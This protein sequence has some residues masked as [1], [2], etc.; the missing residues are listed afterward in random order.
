MDRQLTLHIFQMHL[1]NEEFQK[2]FGMNRAKFY[3]QPKWKIVAAKQSK[4]LF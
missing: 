2:V 3:Q 4:G 1:S